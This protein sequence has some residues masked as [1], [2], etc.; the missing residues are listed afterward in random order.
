MICSRNQR[1]KVFRSL[2]SESNWRTTVWLLTTLVKMQ[3]KKNANRCAVEGGAILFFK[4]TEGRRDRIACTTFRFRK[5]MTGDAS[6]LCVLFHVT[7]V[8]E[9][10]DGASGTGRVDPDGCRQ[11]VDWIYLRDTRL[12]EGY[13]VVVN[14]D[15]FRRYD[16][17][18]KRMDCTATP[19]LQ[20]QR[21]VIYDSATHAVHWIRRVIKLTKKNKITIV[22]STR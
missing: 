1:F 12:P 13:V 5:E 7:R 22:T 18:L 19:K 9:I 10:G 21:H 4:T 3:R 14:K 16:V 11:R 17:W 15:P 2:Y 6:L 20:S 8:P